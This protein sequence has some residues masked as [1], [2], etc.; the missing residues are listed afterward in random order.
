MVSEQDGFLSRDEIYV[1]LQLLARANRVR[2]ELKNFAGQ[3]FAIRMIGNQEKH[4]DPKS[5]I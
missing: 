1:I 4:C 3:K 5:Q 2:I